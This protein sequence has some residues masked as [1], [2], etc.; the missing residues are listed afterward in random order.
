MIFFAA[1]VFLTVI[2]QDA[3]TGFRSASEVNAEVTVYDGRRKE[4]IKTDVDKVTLCMAK[5]RDAIKW[6][7]DWMGFLGI[8]ISLALSIAASDFKGY[9]FLSAASV[10]ALFEVGLILSI[11]CL[12]YVILYS[13]IHRNY[14]KIRNAVEELKTGVIDCNW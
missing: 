6:R 13:I 2:G 1:M 4:E 3:L 11:I 10:T 5:Y 7:T 14:A 8:V 9:W 12:I